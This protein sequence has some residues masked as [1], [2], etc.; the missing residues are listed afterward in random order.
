[1]AKSSLAHR[2]RRRPVRPVSA[3]LFTL[4]VLVPSAACAL[5]E[6]GPS[7]EELRA[8]ATSAPTEEERAGAERRVRD[9][10]ARVAER[11][12]GLRPYSVVTTDSCLR[13]PGYDWKAQEDSGREMTCSVTATAYYGWDED[14]PALLDAVAA[15]FP[16]KEE[17]AAREARVWE[18]LLASGGPYGPS[19][20][21]GLAWDIPGD[22]VAEPR[23]CPEESDH[24]VH[25]RCAVEPGSDVVPLEEIRR[26]HRLV[27]AWSE[28]AGYLAVSAPDAAG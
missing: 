12:P 28:G 15:E 24:I 1:M 9:E 14:I 26:A 19:L 4:L 27:V 3:A 17:V 22:R 18:R 2:A 20:V 10:I 21:T 16:E 8:R 6:G 25:A 23:P 11:L 5:A 13:G 7:A